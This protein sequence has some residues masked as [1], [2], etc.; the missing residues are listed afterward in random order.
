MLGLATD[1]PN[2]KAP[3]VARERETP[4]QIPFVVCLDRFI[5]IFLSLVNS[6]I[7]C[8]P[9]VLMYNWV[10]TAFPTILVLVGPPPCVAHCQWV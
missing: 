10:L 1:Y 6:S 9:D 2:R 8:T 7:T 5:I 4:N 3:L